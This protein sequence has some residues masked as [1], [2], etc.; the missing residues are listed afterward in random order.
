MVMSGIYS[1]KLKSRA[2]D[3]LRIA[4]NIDNHDIAMFL[5]E[6]A[7]Q[8]YVKA[9]YFEL[10]GVKVRGHGIRELLG[11]LA[12]DLEAQGY[13]ELA[14]EL[15]DFVA[16]NRDV[17][18]ML[19]EAYVESRYGESSYDINDVSTVLRVVKSLIM[20]LDGLVNRVKLG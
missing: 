11:L 7:T 19:E 1:R 14:R 15:R 13:S 2:L 17:L 18:I 3:A 8:L 6:Q 16:D 9:A 5:I 20:L 10:F 4:E 12:K